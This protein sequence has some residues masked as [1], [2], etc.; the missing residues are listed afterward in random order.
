VL[1]A[2]GRFLSGD[3]PPKFDCPTAESWELA[4][5]RLVAAVSTSIVTKI[6]DRRAPWVS[7][8]YSF[9]HSLVTSIPL[10]FRRS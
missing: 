10:Q 3:G 7:G 2:S 6:E 4:S 9:D 1:S 8:S 5:L